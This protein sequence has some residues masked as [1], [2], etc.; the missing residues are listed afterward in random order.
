MTCIQT[1]RLIRRLLLSS[2]TKSQ[3]R[4][5]MRQLSPEE[6]YLDVTDGRTS[7]TFLSVFVCF[8]FSFLFL[9]Q[10]RL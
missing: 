5:R 4:Q 1:Q 7:G 3:S 6:H 9:L 10:M 2:R 8:F